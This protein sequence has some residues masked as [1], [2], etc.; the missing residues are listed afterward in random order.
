MSLCDWSS[1]VCSS[2]LACAFG[3]VKCGR[4]RATIDSH[5]GAGGASRPFVNGAGDQFLPGP[6]FT[7]DKYGAIR[8]CD[9]GHSRNHRLE[10]RRV[11]YDL[12]KHGHLVDFFAQ[13]NVLLVELVL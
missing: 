4:K 2:D 6:R 7:G 1:E 9:L 5:K 10:G 3:T 13:N 12:L 11:A 8:R